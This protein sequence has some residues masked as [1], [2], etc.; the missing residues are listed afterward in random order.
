MSPL[1]PTAR[2]VAADDG[3][4]T[5]KQRYLQNNASP[6]LLIKYAQKLQP[7]TVDSIRERMTARY[8]GSDNVGKTLVLDQGADATIIGNEHGRRWISPA[9][10]RSG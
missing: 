2:E 3:M 7:G 9:C 10:R 1:T 8:G 6:N 5:Y 4:T